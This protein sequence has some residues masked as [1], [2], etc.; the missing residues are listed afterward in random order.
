VIRDR[1]PVKPYY[2]EDGITIFHGDC[3]EVLPQLD[4]NPGAIITDPPYGI[5]IKP[6]LQ[7][8]GRSHQDHSRVFGDNSPFNPAHLLAYDCP[9]ILW[10]ANN[11][12]PRLPDSNAWIIWYKRE[13]VEPD[14]FFGDAELAWSNLTG[15]PRV[16]SVPWASRVDRKTDGRWHGTQK[17]VSVMRW[18][19]DRISWIT[20]PAKTKSWGGGNP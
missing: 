14:A 18:C 12:A 11:Y 3:R 1:C 6:G 4:L 20:G 8:P 10:G 16:V 17:P 2:E 15:G 19:I 5:N 9:M 13:G 7:M